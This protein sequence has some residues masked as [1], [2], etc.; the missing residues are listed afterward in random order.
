[1]SD[2]KPV[3]FGPGPGRRGMTELHYAAYCGDGEELG[4]CMAA[5][6]DPNKKDE[7]RGYTPLLWLMDMAAIGGPRVET[8]QALVRHGADVHVVSADGTSALTLGR[9]SGNQTGD[10]LVE[11]LRALGAKE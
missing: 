3:L 7:Y 4:R 6:M 5:G 8:L 11:A 2:E 10:D 9:E 1:M